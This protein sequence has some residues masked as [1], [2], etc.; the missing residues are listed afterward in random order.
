MRVPDTIAIE[1]EAAGDSRSTFRLRVDTTVVGENLTAAQAQLL[2]G[3]ILER[4]A[5]PNRDRIGCEIGAAEGELE[6]R[7]GQMFHVAKTTTAWR[8][9]LAAMSA[10]LRQ[11][12][13]SQFLKPM[14]PEW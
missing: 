2:V 7:G 5:L 4:I 8:V 6:P 9:R 14:Q 1:L 10:A 12:A 13:R 3:D 11:S